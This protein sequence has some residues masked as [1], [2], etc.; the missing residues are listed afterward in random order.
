MFEEK[1]IHR[2]WFWRAFPLVPCLHGIL[3][4]LATIQGGALHFGER[5]GLPISMPIWGIWLCTPLS[6][7]FFWFFY[8]N[9]ARQA[10]DE[11]LKR[12]DH[13]DAGLKSLAKT[14]SWTKLEARIQ[15]LNKELRNYDIK[16]L[17]HWLDYQKTYF[18]SEYY[19][20]QLNP[21]PEEAPPIQHPKA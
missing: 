5:F 13:I 3:H 2:K 7:T 4:G 9:L 15:Q 20:N 19:L 6:A 18:L 14:Q 17:K 11:R 1:Q 8:K 12:I 21:E 10:V 16:L